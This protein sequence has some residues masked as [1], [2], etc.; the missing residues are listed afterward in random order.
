MNRK[1]CPKCNRVF[2]GDSYRVRTAFEGHTNYCLLPRKYKVMINI[3]M[4]PSVF[5]FGL[6][7]VGFIAY[8]VLAPVAYPFYCCM[9]DML[10]EKI[11]LWKEYK[12]TV[13][14]KSD[15]RTYIEKKDREREK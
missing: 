2:E 8:F 14:G 3:F 13:Y 6:V 15:L 4:I 11:P 12:E 1:K 10:G 7:F 9:Q 5:A